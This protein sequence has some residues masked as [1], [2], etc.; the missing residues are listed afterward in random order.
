MRQEF[1]SGNTGSELS[2]SGE[3]VVNARGKDLYLLSAANLDAAPDCL[4]TFTTTVDH[5]LLDQLEGK[6]ILGLFAR[7]FHPVL[8]FGPA[9]CN[10]FLQV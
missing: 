1:H 5:L 2:G 10:N 9:T 4:Q 8:C 6:C 3:L 7:Y